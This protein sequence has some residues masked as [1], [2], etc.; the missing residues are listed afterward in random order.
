MLCLAK[1]FHIDHSHTTVTAG[2]LSL[3]SQLYLVRSFCIDLCVDLENSII[4]FYWYELGV[5]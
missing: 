5:N 3:Q 1:V 2:S 4:Q